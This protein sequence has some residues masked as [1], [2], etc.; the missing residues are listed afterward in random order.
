[1]LAAAMLRVERNGHWPTFEALVADVN[2]PRGIE[3]GWYSA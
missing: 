1:M 2:S 3:S